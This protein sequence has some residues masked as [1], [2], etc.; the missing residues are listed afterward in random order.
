MW[1]STPLAA[2]VARTPHQ[3]PADL[4]AGGCSHAATEIVAPV[5][6]HA[7]CFT[8]LRDHAIRLM[9]WREGSEPLQRLEHTIINDNRPVEIRSAVDDAVSHG[10]KRQR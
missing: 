10:D 6:A 5:H 3:A 2:N 7:T 1:F 8:D 4:A 9:E